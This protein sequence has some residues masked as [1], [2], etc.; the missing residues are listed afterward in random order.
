M[1]LLY[2]P[3]SP[4]SRK[5]RV[6]AAELDIPLELAKIQRG[7]AVLAE[8]VPVLRG[9]LSVGVIAAACA[10]GYLD[11]RLPAFDWRVAAW[12]LAAW[13][14]EFA[15]RPSMRSTRHPSG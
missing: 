8:L 13:S 12:Q 2:T 5:V 14:D 11:L 4:Y 9:P 7:V 1:E 10:L 15:D 6:V 3:T